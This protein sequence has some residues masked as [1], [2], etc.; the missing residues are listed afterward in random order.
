MSGHLEPNVRGDLQEII[1]AKIS[2][3]EEIKAELRAEFSSLVDSVKGISDARHVA[4]QKNIDD[5]REEVIRQSQERALRYLHRFESIERAL[6]KVE[7]APALLQ[8]TLT[9]GVYVTQPSLDRVID[10]IKEQMTVVRGLNTGGLLIRLEAAEKARDILADATQKRQ[11]I[12]DALLN[13]LKVALNSSD[14]VVD[15]RAQAANDALERLLNASITATKEVSDVRHQANQLAI[16][17]VKSQVS[18]AFAAAQTGLASALTAAKAEVEAVDQ[19]SFMRWENAENLIKAVEDKL[20]GLIH[21]TEEKMVSRISAIK[22]LLDLTGE[23]NKE[24]INKAE[25][26]QDRRLESMNEFRGQ[27]S[28]QSATLLPR[29]EAEARFS[30]MAEKLELLKN[31]SAKETGK[32]EGYG[33]MIAT[34]L[35]VVAIIISIGMVYVSSANHNPTVGVDTNRVSDLITNLNAQHMQDSARMDAL[36]ARINALTPPLVQSQP[37]K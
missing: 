5:W 29:I 36:S 22:D 20:L 16:I 21:A 12:T 34:G 28:D 33:Q 24:A 17:E 25:A 11:L 7:A 37:I 2:L 15:A 6:E 18:S 14:M 8:S 31:F 10:D 35:S 26:S 3:R 30:S 4:T 27:M 32:S 13:D 1:A 9:N 19:K 23:L